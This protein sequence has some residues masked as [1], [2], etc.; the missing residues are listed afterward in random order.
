MSAHDR[1]LAMYRRGTDRLWCSNKNCAV[2]DDGM[3]VDWESEYGIATYLIEE[4]P[5]CLC[6]WLTEAPQ[7]DEED[8]DDD[9]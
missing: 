3:E 6:P 7:D 5:E 9:Q 2:H 4:C 8:D 1:H